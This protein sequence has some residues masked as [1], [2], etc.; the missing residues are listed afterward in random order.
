M[1]IISYVGRPTKSHQLT[2]GIWRKWN[3]SGMECA[4]LNT[5]I[6]NGLI[7]FRVEGPKELETGRTRQMM[8]WD[9]GYG[10]FGGGLEFRPRLELTYEL[11]PEVT[12]IYPKEINSIYKEG[13]S[14]NEL[15]AGFD[16][17]G[18]KIYSTLDFNLGSIPSYDYTMIVDAYLELNSTK[19]YL[20][21]D[22]RFHLELVDESMEKNNDGLS[23]REVIQNIGYDVSANELKNNQTQYFM[24]DEFANRILNQKLKDNSDI[25]FVLKPTASK[26]AIKNKT[27]TWEMGNKELS[28]KLVIEHIPKRRYPVGQIKNATIFN[29]NGKIKL[30]W[31]NPKDK[32]FRGVKVVKNPYRPPLSH[33]DGQKLYAG[34]DSYTY[35]DFGAKDIRKYYSLFTYDDVPNYSAPIILEYDEKT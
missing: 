18:A 21:D 28:P 23:E 16:D 20:K 10:K 25:T 32:D 26:K 34:P 7:T 31:D 3:F 11:E 13:V 5:Q 19:V 4:M 14:Q 6:Q 30:T 15:V 8:Q 17:K 12:T 35:D 29:E 2:Q 27:I 1:E 24:F 22:I 9:L 33:K